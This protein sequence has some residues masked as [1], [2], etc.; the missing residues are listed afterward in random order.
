[1]RRFPYLAI[2]VLLIAA[3]LLWPTPPEA[4]EAVRTGPRASVA[5]IAA[6]MVDYD[7]EA[8]VQVEVDAYLNAMEAERTAMAAELARQEALRTT[9]YAPSSPARGGTSAGPHT[10]AWWAGVAQCEQGGRND[11]YFGY[12]SFM[13]GSSGGKTWEEQVA[14]GNALLERAGREIGPWAAS[15]VAAGYRASP[16]G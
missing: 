14:M 9:Y 16:D 10:D 11:P 3:Y 13:D 1:V 8:A 7:A 6:P 12:F 4:H 15:C 2:P 5:L